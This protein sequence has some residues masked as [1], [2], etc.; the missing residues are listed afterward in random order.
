MKCIITHAG[1]YIYR[2]HQ[3]PL[4]TQDSYKK[5]GFQRSRRG[6]TFSELRLRDMAFMRRCV[7]SVRVTN[8]GT[9]CSTMSMHQ[10]WPVLEPS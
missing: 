1:N 7:F 4:R 3:L 6:Q 10:L 8:S 9:P 5:K 2:T